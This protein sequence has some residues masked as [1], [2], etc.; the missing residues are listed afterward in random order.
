MTCPWYVE[1][2]SW[3]WG[4]G[5][6]V[7]QCGQLRAGC[8]PGGQRRGWDEARV[9]SALS[10]FSP[11]SCLYSECISRDYGNRPGVGDNSVILLVNALEGP[12]GLAAK[13][14]LTHQAAFC[15]SPRWISRGSVI[16]GSF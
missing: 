8:S 14:C 6:A 5:Q 1:L 9:L 7:N 2:W 13:R 15:P 10:T 16:C 11:L 3:S 12:L 4:E